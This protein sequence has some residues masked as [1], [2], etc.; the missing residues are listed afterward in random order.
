MYY[1]KQGETLIA[2]TMLPIKNLDSYEIITKEE[3]EKLQ[4]EGIA[5]EQEASKWQEQ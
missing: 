3:Y 5:A 1:L 4:A 2:S